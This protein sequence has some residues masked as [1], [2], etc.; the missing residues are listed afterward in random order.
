MCNFWVLFWLVLGL[1]V[2]IS[3]ILFFFP[4]RFCQCALAGEDFIASGDQ[5]GENVRGEVS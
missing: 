4:D 5:D 3:A 1:C 2:F